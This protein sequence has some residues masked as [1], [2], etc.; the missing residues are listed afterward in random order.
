MAAVAIPRPRLASGP[1][2]GSER[3]HGGIWIVEIT[4]PADLRDHKHLD[5][6]EHDG[7]MPAV[8][9]LR[10]PFT[11]ESVYETNPGRG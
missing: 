4:G 5:I 8:M 9:K 6:G 10:G 11:C 2:R 1:L 3:P 7:T